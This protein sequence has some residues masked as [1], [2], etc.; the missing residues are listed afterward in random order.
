VRFT[1]GT[2]FGSFEIISPLGAGGMGEVYRARDTRL[3]RQVAVKLLLDSFSHDPDRLARFEREAK[4]L[5]SLNHPNIAQVH[6]LEEDGTTKALVMELVEGPTLADRLAEGPVPLDEALGIARQIGDA[7][8]TAHDQGIVHRDLKPA[9]IKL[10]R[11]GTVKVLDFG[12]AKL[13][14]AGAAGQG[15]ASALTMSPTI[16]SPAMTQAGVILGTAAYM[17]PEQARGRTV[18]RRADIWAFG[19]VLYEMLAGERPFQGDDLTETLASVVKDQADLRRLP[20]RV[21]RLVARCLE[22]DP[23]RRLRDIG[24]AWDL[25]DEPDAATPP[26]A[27]PA[28]AVRRL[29]PWGAA[30]ACALLAATIAAVHFREPAPPPPS[31]V[32]FQIAAAQTLAGTSIPAISPDGRRIVYQQGS[33]IFVRDFDAIVPRML[34]TSD[35]GVAAPFWSADSR[36]VIYDQ[37]GK[38]AKIDA[39]GGPPQIICALSGIMLGGFEA[40]DGRIVFNAVPGGLWQVPVAGGEPTQLGPGL[41][42]VT[43]SGGSSLLPGGRRFVYGD[44]SVSGRE[45]VYVSNLDGS[46]DPVRVLSGA[47]QAVAYVPD[48]RNGGGHLLFRRDATLLAQRFDAE[49]FRVIGD[50]L[51]VAERISAFSAS[52]SGAVLYNDIG[53]GRRLTWVDRDGDGVG[54]VWAPGQYNELSLSRD[55]SRLAVVRADGTSTW[56]HEFAREASFRL[57][58]ALRSS[59][60]PVWSPDGSQLA[61]AS[62]IDG[63]QFNIYVAPANG[64][65]SETLLYKSTHSKYPTSWSADGRFLLF[66][67]IDPSTRH[68]LWVMPMAATAE[69]KPEPFLVTNYREFDATFSPDGRFVAYVSD[70]SGTP[71]VYV[72]SFPSATGGKWAVSNGGGYQPRWRGD[73][74]ELLYVS[75][76]A[77]LMSVNTTLGEGFTG[78]SPRALFTAAIYGGGQSINNWYWDIAPDGKRMLFNAGSTETGT[79][80]VTVV[81]NWQAGLAR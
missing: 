57:T 75:G 2:R 62:S 66:T 22:K 20:A 43:V 70:E 25:L 14:E 76:R 79:G 26:A 38:L 5:A 16:T 51:S 77:R 18:D 29:L 4:L 42:V 30:A 12:L 36:F 52:E 54:T 58:T 41:R 44:T 34:T 74:K 24:D 50:P 45:G 9:N 56:I 37:A 81:L 11:D 60:K 33:Q 53:E 78:G 72:R 28:A 27:P 48:R 73:G 69:H 35:A 49:S 32:R 8:A 55:G 67:T 64:S 19:V 61:F 46:G 15:G 68:D 65:G 39:S 6:G 71:E 7:L 40:P 47:I 10:R 80:L 13:T 31:V 3:D 59:V 63:G 1:A 23:R 21:R 17:S